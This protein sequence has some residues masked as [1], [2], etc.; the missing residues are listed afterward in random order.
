MLTEKKIIGALISTLHDHPDSTTIVFNS[1]YELVGWCMNEAKKIYLSILDKKD[2][3][4]IRKG[5]KYYFNHN[6]IGFNNLY[7]SSVQ[8]RVIKTL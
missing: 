6:N 5:I 4:S 2:M 1:N 3:D 7:I 8:K